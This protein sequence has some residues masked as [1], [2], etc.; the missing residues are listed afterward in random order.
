LPGWSTLWSKH[1]EYGSRNPVFLGR[2]IKPWG[3]GRYHEDTY[4]GRSQQ[5]MGDRRG[6]D[7]VLSDGRWG[8]TP[9]RRPCPDLLP[10]SGPELD[11]VEVPNVLTSYRPPLRPR[12]SPSAAVSCGCRRPPSA[13]RAPLL[14]ACG[15]AMY[16]WWGIGGGWPM[17][18]R[19]WKISR[20]EAYCWAESAA[21]EYWLKTERETQEE[22]DREPE[23]GKGSG[24]RSG[25]DLRWSR[26]FFAW[27]GRSDEGFDVLLTTEHNSFLS[28]IIEIEIQAYY[29]SVEHLAGTIFFG[30]FLPNNVLA[31]QW[32]FCWI[33]CNDFLNTKNWNGKVLSK[34]GLTYTPI[35]F[36]ICLF[37][38]SQTM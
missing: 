36:W 35:L 4:H 32:A 9:C 21:G 13:R 10:P 11:A 18:Q 33:P 27:C 22:D 23:I 3:E 30:I 29:P 8:G 5:G 26:L 28:I 31:I 25:G 19:G 12:A 15:D 34:Q 14:L 24:G 2:N 16:L 1:A 37:Y 20:D 17:E 38:I 7:S 6:R